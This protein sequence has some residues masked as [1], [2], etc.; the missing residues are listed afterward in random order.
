MLKEVL[1]ESS[2]ILFLFLLMFIYKRLNMIILLPTLKKKKKTMFFKGVEL[3]WFK[4][5][6]NAGPR[7]SQHV[8]N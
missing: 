7:T 4:Q 5:K 6:K 2:L 1:L 8:S 3:N